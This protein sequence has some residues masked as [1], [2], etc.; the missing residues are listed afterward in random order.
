MTRKGLK[1]AGLSMLLL[2][3]PASAQMRLAG[4][5]RLYF[6]HVAGPGQPLPKPLPLAPLLPETLGGPGAAWKPAE[7]LEAPSD[8]KVHD[9]ELPSP[10]SKRRLWI[11]EVENH[12][13][14]IADLWWALYDDGRRSDVWEFV[15]SLDR[16]DDKVLS[17]YAL[18]GFSMPE[19]DVVIF[20]VRGEMFRPQGAWWV[21]GKEWSFKVNGSALTLDRVRNVFGF[22][23]GYDTGKKAASLSVSTESESGG[24]FE[25][26]ALDAVSKKTQQACGFRDPMEDDGWRSSWV[27]QVKAAQCITGKPGAKITFR[28]LDAP[29]FIERGGSSE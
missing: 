4:L 1:V 14:R 25:T 24:R 10:G 5:E 23:Q 3:P 6:N 2:A 27:L 12:G 29:S 16:T 9:F 15:A 8:L 20:R 11:R 13:T 21:V 19:K 18:D 26:R 28:K 22:S 17:N 7:N